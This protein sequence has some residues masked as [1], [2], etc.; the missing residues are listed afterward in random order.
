MLR[1]GLP[2]LE[3]ERQGELRDDISD[4]L[5]YVSVTPTHPGPQFPVAPSRVVGAHKPFGIVGAIVLVQ[6]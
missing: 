5:H 2:S 1:A 6:R 4:N 3:V